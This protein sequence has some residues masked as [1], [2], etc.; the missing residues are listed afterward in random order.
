MLDGAINMINHIKEKLAEDH[1]K[2]FEIRDLA[3]RYTCDVSAS[4]TFAFEANSFLSENPPILKLARNILVGITESV[5][6]M[7]P[8]KMIPKQHENDF[9][10]VMTDAMKLRNEN[11]I[12]RDDFLAHIIAVKAKKGQTDIEAA[13]HGWTFFFDA[14]ETAGIVCHYALYEL[15]NDKR[16]QEKLRN[17]IYENLNEDGTL[18]YEKLIE[19]PYLDQVLYE[20]MRLHPPFMFTT[21]VCSEDIELDAVKGHKFMMKKGSTALISMYSIHRDPGNHNI[22]R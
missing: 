9:I 5:L 7:F 8:K 1:G 4:C 19:L 16:V 21:K 20:V 3:S 2:A 18:P 22:L 14:F 10:K 17:E 12:E 6:S 15:A 13:A 11:K